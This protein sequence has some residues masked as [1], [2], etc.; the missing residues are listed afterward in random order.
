MCRWEKWGGHILG[1]SIEAELFGAYI[2]LNYMK[3]TILMVQNGLI[4]KFNM[5]KPT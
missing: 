3:I 5:I 1:W 2:D 4:L